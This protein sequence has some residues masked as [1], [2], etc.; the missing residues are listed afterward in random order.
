[1]YKTAYAQEN[2]ASATTQRTLERRVIQQSIDL[3]SSAAAAD[4]GA[5]MKT[6]AIVF[7]R[8][9]WTLLLED[10]GNSDNALPEETRASLISVGLWVLRECDDI[11]LGKSNNFTGLV[12]VST[13]IRDGLQ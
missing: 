9:L 13:S 12:E 10:L 11:R 5:L 8:R 2:A 4:A 6:E 3:L 1:M 7:T